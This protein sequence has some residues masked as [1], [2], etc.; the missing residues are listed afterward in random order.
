MGYKRDFSQRSYSSGNLN[1]W[2]EYFNYLIAPLNA[3]LAQR[4]IK[5]GAI[6]GTTATRL[7]MDRTT[8][9]QTIGR[10]TDEIQYLNTH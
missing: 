2:P 9:S 5:T 4:K 7:C 3:H 6:E 10:S 1:K 8:E